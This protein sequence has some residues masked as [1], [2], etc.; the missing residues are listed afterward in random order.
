MV[1][2]LDRCAQPPV[3]PPVVPPPMVPAAA[4]GAA[5]A[6]R[7]SSRRR[8]PPAGCAACGAA[9][10]PTVPPW[11]RWCR[12]W[13][14]V[15]VPG[16][17]ISSARGVRERECAMLA[18]RVGL[19]L[20]VEVD[21]DLLEEVVADGDEPDFDG[22]LKVLKPPELAEQVGD[23][24][25]DLG[26]VPDDQADAEEE[27]NDRAGRTFWASMP[28]PAPPPPPGATEPLAEAIGRGDVLAR[29][30]PGPA[31]CPERSTS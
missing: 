21:A 12:W 23:L 24:L 25:M 10:V 2:T 6:H 8:V 30:R 16:I 11:C 14:M 5:C 17:A 26:R 9:V 22:D 27:G 19:D 18:D 29:S 13:S 1:L 3:V 15:G 20:E 4:C 31:R 28:P 7:L